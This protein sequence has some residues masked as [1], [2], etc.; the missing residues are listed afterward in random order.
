M[1]SIAAVEAEAMDTTA[2]ALLLRNFVDL[3]CIWITRSSGWRPCWSCLVGAGVVALRPD[4]RIQ[5]CQVTLDG[6]GLRNP[7]GERGGPCA[8][9]KTVTDLAF[10]AI[11]KHGA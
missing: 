1:A 4:L 5:L 3:H 11:L 10:E 2:E 7:V 8:A 6:G 9:N